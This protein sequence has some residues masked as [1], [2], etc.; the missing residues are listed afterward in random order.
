MASSFLFLNYFQQVFRIVL[1]CAGC[2]FP[3]LSR[4]NVQQRKVPLTGREIKTI[5]KIL[6]AIPGKDSHESGTRLQA[7]MP[8]QVIPQAGTQSGS[9]ADRRTVYDGDA[10]IQEGIRQERTAF[11]QTDGVTKIRID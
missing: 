8:V 3:S 2:L 4:K 6:D 10:Q 11:R 1:I 7:E 5:G 9:H